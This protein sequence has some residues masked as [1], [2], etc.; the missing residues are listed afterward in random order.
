M[1]FRVRADRAREGRLGDGAGLALERA[2]ADGRDAF[3]RRLAASGAAP[4]HQDA[5][6]Q[7]DD[8]NDAEF[9]RGDAALA[10]AGRPKGHGGS[11]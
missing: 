8:G 5:D 4:D 1:A 10:G 6:G 11:M 7:Q 9:A 3:Q 2:A